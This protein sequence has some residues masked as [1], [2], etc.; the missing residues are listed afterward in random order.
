MNGIQ[1][2]VHRLQ[3]ASEIQLRLQKREEVTMRMLCQPSSLQ[4]PFEGSRTKTEMT[5]KKAESSR[6]LTPT[7]ER[8]QIHQHR[9]FLK[10]FPAGRGEGG[11]AGAAEEQRRVGEEWWRTRGEERMREEGGRQRSEGEGRVEFDLMKQIE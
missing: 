9:L 4:S 10:D 1:G 7:L 2:A 5:T 8:E 6:Y 3:L 11:R